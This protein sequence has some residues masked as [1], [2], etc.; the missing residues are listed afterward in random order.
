MKVIELIELPVYKAFLAELNELL[1][2]PIDYAYRLSPVIFDILERHL[3]FADATGK[4][5]L[6]L[7]ENH[8]QAALRYIVDKDIEM[9]KEPL[10]EGVVEVHPP[11]VIFAIG[12]LIEFFAL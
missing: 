1:P 4:D 12:H 8:K 10:E 2:E 5:L 7:I 9:S 3:S 11:T 6:Y